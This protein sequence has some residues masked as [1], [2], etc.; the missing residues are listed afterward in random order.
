MQCF[1]N[2]GEREKIQGLDIL[3]LRQLDQNIERKWVAGITTISYRARYL[4]LLPWITAEF[5][6]KEINEGGGKGHFDAA[7][8]SKVLSRM[9]FVVLAASKIGT[10]WGESG[11]TYGVLGS[12]LY[13]GELAE[14]LSNHRVEISSDHHGASYGTYIMPCRSFG[15]L[16]APA[17]DTD[18]PVEIVPRGE[19]IHK[20]RRETLG[21]SEL[22]KLILDG[23]LLNLEAIKREG[24]HFSL[25]GLG[26][27]SRELELLRASFFTPYLKDNTVLES[28]RC[29]N[30]TVRW[31]LAGISSTGKSSNDLIFENFRDAVV[32]N[33][34]NL[35]D[36]Q[37]A[38]AEYELRR[39]VHSSLELLLCA[40]TDT[41]MDLTEATVQQILDAWPSSERLPS[42]LTEILQ[43]DSVPLETKL[44]EIND[45]LP[46]GAFLN[47]PLDR[48]T[49]RTLTPF[50]QALYAL[51]MLLNCQRLTEQLRG[52]GKI[53]KRDHYMERIFTLLQN[54]AQKT[55]GEI[56]SSALIETAI[57]PHLTTTLRKM[58][59]GQKCSLRFYPEGD[60]LRPTGK[61]VAAG[62]SGDRLTNV[63]GMLA[64]LGLC[65]REEGGK[66]ALN[67]EGRAFVG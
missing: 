22:T 32:G 33:Q 21:Q 10:E 57:E 18:V 11:I 29:F 13:A 60:L 35:S 59:Q 52:A 16:A 47:G 50:P 64:D 3:G 7:R 38:W 55:V 24:H 20:A 6:R 56:L 28:Y 23:G 46:V 12:D 61:T 58:G 25:N 1:W 65:D 40:L 36:T 39:R 41:L 49:G 51:A 4:S 63:L 15:I 31:A 62:F 43:F 27:N 54:G 19:D 2:S 17:G 67:D 53:P 34:A 48:K 44:G 5:F 66:F 14:L 45:R 26:H 30:A 8:Y 42:L 9:E 37:L